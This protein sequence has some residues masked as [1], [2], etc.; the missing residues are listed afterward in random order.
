MQQ[1]SHMNRKEITLIKSGLFYAQFLN[2]KSKAIH[3]SLGSI[4][5]QHAVYYGRYEL[6][7]MVGKNLNIFQQDFTTLPEH[8]LFDSYQKEQ[9]IMLLAVLGQK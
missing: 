9:L 3:L 5:P 8:N 1:F 6:G 4:Q 2:L 7:D